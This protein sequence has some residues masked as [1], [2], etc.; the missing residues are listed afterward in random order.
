MT[1]N[2]EIDG[3]PQDWKA[4][5]YEVTGHSKLYAVFQHENSDRE[6]HVVP[7]KTYELPTL[8]N[9]H[10]VTVQDLSH[11]L[12]VIAEGLDVETVEDAEKA[13]I[14]AMESG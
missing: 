11:R 14:S 2:S 3:L 6:V 10:R 13:A 5:E 12:E 7:Y 1:D 4:K 8:P 9:V